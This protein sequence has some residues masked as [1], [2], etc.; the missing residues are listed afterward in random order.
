MVIFWLL[1]NSFFCGSIMTIRK[2]LL[3]ISRSYFSSLQGNLCSPHAILANLDSL[4]T[5]SEHFRNLQ[6]VLWRPAKG[7]GRIQAANFRE[8][9]LTEF[10]IV[11]QWFSGVPKPISN[12]LPT[13]GLREVFIASFRGV[14]AVDGYS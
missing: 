4:L 6:C 5:T 14:L 8:V 3:T 13:K 9:P 1:L 11:S 12:L 10:L 2:L 7:F